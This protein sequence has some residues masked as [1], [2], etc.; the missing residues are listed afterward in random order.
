[1]NSKLQNLVTKYPYYCSKSELNRFLD[2]LGWT[3]PSKYEGTEW[4][5]TERKGKMCIHS[6]ST[7]KEGNMYQVWKDALNYNL[8]LWDR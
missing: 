7:I 3:C 4:Y 8:Y 2:T 6:I 1:M 5:L